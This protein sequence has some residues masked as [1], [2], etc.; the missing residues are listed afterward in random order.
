MWVIVFSVL[1]SLSVISI[2]GARAGHMDVSRTILRTL[3][4][5]SVT[6]VVSYLVGQIAF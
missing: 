3:L 1:L 4:V 2:V 6:I 5:A